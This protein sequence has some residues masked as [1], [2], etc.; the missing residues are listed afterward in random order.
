MK[1]IL[2]TPFIVLSMLMLTGCPISEKNTKEP[3][4]ESASCELGAH[5]SLTP[6]IEQAKVKMKHP[7]C[8]MEFQTIFDDLLDIAEESGASLEHKKTF[9][10][11]LLWAEK[12]GL[13]SKKQMKNTYGRYFS[14]KFVSS[15]VNNQMSIA[16]SVC[17]KRNG[18]SQ[19]HSSMDV[20][21]I[22]KQRGL[23]KVLGDKQEY[24]QAK[25]VKENLMT[26]IEATCSAVDNP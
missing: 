6:A 11:F 26:V 14:S 3:V 9:T 17:A 23:L 2:V 24:R 1:K 18:L 5:K 7:A 16:S 13:I 20:E 21:L 4:V 8:Q 12:E 25:A 22:D 19:V 15:A 10:G